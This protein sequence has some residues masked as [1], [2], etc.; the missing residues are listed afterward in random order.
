MVE[1]PGNGE[2]YKCGLCC[3]Q[4]KGRYYYRCDK[5]DF[6]L[7][8][9]C[10]EFPET[11]SGFFAHPWHDLRLM[12]DTDKGSKYC[13]LCGE[14]MV[15]F[16]CRCIPCNVDLHPHCTKNQQTIKAEMHPKHGLHLVPSADNECTACKSSKRQ[17]WLYRCGECKVQYHIKCVGKI[18]RKEQV[19]K[20]STESS[21]NKTSN[22]GR[23]SSLG[24]KVGDKVAV[25]ISTITTDV[26][27]KLVLQLVSFFFCLTVKSFQSKTLLFILFCFLGGILQRFWS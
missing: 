7:H 10:A 12:P 24:R 14:S 3:T 2:N 8:K 25:E 9:R 6:N 20:N 23:L 27:T 18:I 22:L 1:R 11:I 16:Y 15:G 4:R 26:L 13:D 5:C 21:V 19:H 17:I